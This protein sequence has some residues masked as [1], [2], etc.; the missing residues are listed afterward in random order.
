MVRSKK[1]SMHKKS[2]FQPTE[3]ATATPTAST[4]TAIKEM[5][6]TAV[7]A[8]KDNNSDRKIEKQQQQHS[9][10]RIN[11]DSINSKITAATAPFTA[12]AS[13]LQGSLIDAM[14]YKTTAINSTTPIDQANLTISSRHSTI[15]IQQPTTTTATAAAATTN[16]ITIPQ[17]TYQS[18]HRPLSNITLVFVLVELR[19]MKNSR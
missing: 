13:S 9:I 4:L 8:A 12:T 3:Q 19:I 6:S 11:N 18:P 17:L 5:A 2:I 1:K 7:A 14:S 10:D 15:D 16:K